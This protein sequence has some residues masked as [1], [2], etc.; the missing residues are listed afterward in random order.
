MR[1]AER[2]RQAERGWERTGGGEN[3]GRDRDGGDRGR[4]RKRQTGEE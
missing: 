1:E 2:D 4:E 3:K